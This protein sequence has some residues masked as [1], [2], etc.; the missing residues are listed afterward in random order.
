MESAFAKRRRPMRAT[1]RPFLDET[2]DLKGTNLVDPDQVMPKG[3][4]AK[5]ENCRMYARDEDDSRVAIRTRKGSIKITLPV[6][7]TLD[8]KNIDANTGD[9]SFTTTRIVAQPFTAESAGALTRVA[10]EIKRDATSRGHVIVQI[11]TDNGGVPGTVVAESSILASAIT[12]SYQYLDSYLVDAPS[13]IIG[14]DLWLL[15]S[16]QDNGSG[17]YYVRQTADAGALDLESTDEGASWHSLGVS[18]HFK[19]YVSDDEPV[20]GYKRVYPSSGGPRTY[21]A[22]GTHVYEAEDDGT[23]ASIYASI[24]SGTPFVRFEFFDDILYWVDGVGTPKQYNPAAPAVT[25]VPDA[26]TGAT[27]VISHQGRLFFILSKTLARFSE[28]Y[29]PG[30]YPDT[31]FFYVPSPRSSDPVTGWRVFQDDLLIFTHE[32]KHT[33]YGSEISDFQRKEAVGTKGAVSDEAIAVDR[34]NCYFMD[35]EGHINAWNGAKDKLLSRVMEPEF[36]AI[37]DKS[38]VR[39][40]IYRNQLRVYYA[41]ATS[42]YND[43]RAILDLESGEWFIDT[44]VPLTGS[45]EW[46]QDENQ[47]IEFSSRSP[48]M[49]Q[50]E[51]SHADVGK[52][53]SFKYWTNYKIYGSGIAKKRVKSFEPIVRTVDSDYTLYV[54][55]DMDYQNRPDMREY[56]VSGGGAKWGAFVW[57]DGTKFGKNRLVSRRSGMSGRG[58][59]I[60][61]RFERDGVETPAEI[62]GYA[63]Q[64]KIGRLR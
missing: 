50:G 21:F 9:L 37:P 42:A 57:G 35:D 23:V 33:I 10:P 25:S 56:L 54:G 19:S 40:H 15:L 63:A 52:A 38:K 32:T 5:A 3:H 28:L 17:S 26:P 51:Q 48:W 1:S 7:E 45:L 47:L 8:A 6:N 46:D 24:D 39:L 22:A 49:L 41:S 43:R 13:V 44:G 4:A 64:V 12:T 20:K 60:Q 14:T 16:I 11:C 27:H 55:K 2:Y 29:E 61:Y 53:I 59:H 36:S 34:D 62:Y 31:N 18:Y 58:R 30:D